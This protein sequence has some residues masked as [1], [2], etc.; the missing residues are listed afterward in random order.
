MN[1]PIFR[2]YKGQ[3]SVEYLLVYTVIV[4]LLLVLIIKDGY[5]HETLTNTNER[6]ADRMTDAADKIFP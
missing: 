2:N 4:A 5:F 3:S 6:A 1:I